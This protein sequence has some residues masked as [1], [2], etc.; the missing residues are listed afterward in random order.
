[1]F[2]DRLVHIAYRARE[3][4][5]LSVEFRG[6]KVISTPAPSSGSVFLLA[7]GILECF[8]HAGVA[9][10]L[11]EAHRVIEATKVRHK[12]V[13]DHA[14]LSDLRELQVAFA[15]RALLGDPS[16]VPGVK[17]L[18]AN[19]TSRA[20]AQQHRKR[21]SEATTQPPDFYNEKRYDTDLSNHN[22]SADIESEARTSQQ[23]TGPA[24]SRAPILKV[25]S[26]R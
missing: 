16:F 5:P 6:H 25:S 24:T 3:N 20:T 7:L 11:S 14:I 12:P 4:V 9:G 26:S 21:L 2:A 1:M 17:A 10:T 8:G 13:L 15:S 23:T 18:E 19:F 22:Q